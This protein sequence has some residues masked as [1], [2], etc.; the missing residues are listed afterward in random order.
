MLQ[1]NLNDD[2]SLRKFEACFKIVLRNFMVLY[3]NMHC[4]LQFWSL[5]IHYSNIIDTCSSK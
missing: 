2:N 3:I 1:M 5:L 4:E